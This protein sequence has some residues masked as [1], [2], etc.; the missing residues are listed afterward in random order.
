MAQDRQF[1]ITFHEGRDLRSWP[2]FWNDEQ[3]RQL[4]YHIHLLLKHGNPARFYWCCGLREALEQYD[5]DRIRG[6]IAEHDYKVR[7]IMC[8]D[9]HYSPLMKKDDLYQDY[10][11][12]KN[13]VVR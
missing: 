13:I 1:I 2:R 12:E 5:F 3:C 10:R 7:E 9:V 8:W 4:V 11:T 6:W